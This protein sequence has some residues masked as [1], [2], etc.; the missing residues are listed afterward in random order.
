MQKDLVSILTPCYNTGT[1]LY[2]LLDSILMQDYP[3][4]E[5]FTINDGST[6]NT[7]EVIK[8]YI[9]KFK[10]KGYK[11]TYI[12]QENSGQSAAINKG[13]KLVNGEFLIW[14]D[15]DD[16]FSSNSA[17]STFVSELKN[18]NNDYAIARSL[19][20]E[21]AENDCQIISQLAINSDIAAE[22]QFLNCLYSKN[23]IW[24]PVNYMI[25]MDAF[26]KVNPKREI[27][28]EKNAGQNWQMLLPLLFSYKCITINKHLCR[29][30]VRK[31]S[32][33]R[34]QYSTYKQLLKRISSYRNTLINTLDRIYLMQDSEKQ[35]YKKEIINNY[36]L[37][38][39]DLSVIYGNKEDEHRLILEL[40]AENIAIPYN[41][42]RKIKL[43]RSFLGKIAHYIIKTIRY[44]KKILND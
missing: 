26:D 1:I 42:L 36:K 34:G 12:Y 40:E 19:P 23:F 32:H 24:P 5:M 38:E 6:D 9:P 31:A 8:S 30:L 4:I 21:V 33:S 16:F 2:R 35:K 22:E 17:I 39:L 18:H 27:Y 7:E 15:S 11:L 41:K 13:L 43:R 44:S 3:F 29:V 10:A 14:P 37:Q 28:V 20:T 25:K